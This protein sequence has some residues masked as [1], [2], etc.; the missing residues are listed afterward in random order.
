MTFRSRAIDA[1]IG[2]F[3]RRHRG[4]F[5]ELAVLF[6]EGDDFVFDF[7][8]AFAVEEFFVDEEFFIDDD[9]VALFPVS[10]LIFGNVFGGIVLGVAAAPKRF[11]FDEDR[12]FAGAGA[13]D[14]FF[15]GGVNGDNIVAIDD[16][17]GDAVGFG[18]IG[19]IFD[20]D[21]AAH[22]RGI[23]PQ[24]IFENENERGFLGGGEIQAFVEDA[25]GAAAVA[26]PGHGHDFLAKVAAGHGYAGHDGDEI[27]EHGDWRDDV[28][29]IEIAKVAGAVFAFCGRGVLGH[30]L[31]ENI[32]RR[33]AFYEERADVADHWSH[34]VAPF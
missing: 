25:S 24:I 34:P 19:K 20:G 15:G 28:E 33:D 5:G 16:V 17:T 9:G 21:L 32:A 18:A 3:R 4:I 6:E 11:G 1:L 26:D 29:I 10:T 12:T 30:V 7:F 8:F 23:G 2:G 22:G 14:G 27:A 31:G 13:F